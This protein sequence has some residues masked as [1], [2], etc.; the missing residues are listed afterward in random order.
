M[1]EEHNIVDGSIEVELNLKGKALLDEKIEKLNRRAKRL[2]VAPVTV[3]R[4][5]HWEARK[6]RVRGKDRMVDF[7]RFR[8]SLDIPRLAGWRFLATIEHLGD[9]NLVKTSPHAGEVDLSA[10]RSGSACC[11]HC[12]KPRDRKDTYVIEHENGKRMQVGSSCL[13]DVLGLGVTPEQVADWASWFQTVVNTLSDSSGDD[14]YD[15]WDS[16]RQVTSCVLV[17]YL[18]Y[19]EALIARDGYRSRKYCE[20]NDDSTPTSS[21]ALFHMMPPKGLSAKQRAELVTP[22]DADRAFAGAAIAWAAQ[23]DVRSD[24]DH[25]L[26]TI[27]RCEVID[28]RNKGIAAY[29]VAGYRRH[30]EKEVERR[31]EKLPE[32]R[33]VGEIGKRIK[34]AKVI[35]LAT[36]F[37]GDTAYGVLFIHKFRDEAGNDLVW[38]TGTNLEE[39]P[40]TEFNAAFTP[41]KHGEWNGRA[42]TEVSRMVLD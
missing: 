7:A 40:G 26:Q 37:A 17:T 20:L 16:G 33:H 4:V 42:Q 36:P 39:A 28:F 5:S 6:I 19:V 30:L 31:K 21:D 10:Y 15:G 3:A 27:A 29:I 22:D 11:E 41:K 14:D 9:A 24:F 18:S 1:I 23:I 38:K 13:C 8:V 2:G 25:N 32:S 12:N 34:N 35:Y